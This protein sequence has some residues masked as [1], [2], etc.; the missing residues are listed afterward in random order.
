MSRFKHAHVMGLIGVCLD[1]GSAPYIIMPY[2]ANGSLLKYLKRERNNIVVL[3]ETDE[4]ELGEVRK[5]LMVICSQ[6]A[7]GM[8]YMA[9]NKYVHRDLAA[10]NCMIDAHFLIKITD[11]GLSE[12]VFER[13]Y[14][15]QDSSSG[16]MVKLPIKWMSPESLSDG[17]FSEKSDVWSYGVT[18]WEIFSGGKAPYPGTNPLTLMESL[19]QGYRMPQPY[20]DA[21]SEAI[22]HMMI[23][24][25]EMAVEDRPTFSEISLTISKFI[26]HIAGYLQMGYN[27]FKRGAGK[28]EAEEDEDDEHKE[29][30]EKEKEEE[31][32]ESVV[33]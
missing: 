12:D 29:E 17:H 14:F 2:M 7:S 27:P 25:W 21:C 30:D 3:D 32:E 9:A 23:Q 22:Y 6:I 5:R 20:N 8:E 26:E 1:A 24:C 15:R 31:K 18:M 13:N 19:E 10:R 4:D 11:F 16:E 28:G 33:D